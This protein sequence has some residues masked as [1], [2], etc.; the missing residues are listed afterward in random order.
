MGM[1]ALE[2]R[3]ELTLGSAGS[4]RRQASSGRRGTGGGGRVLGDGES[5]KGGESDS[6]VELHLDEWIEE[7]TDV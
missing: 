1:T 2:R 4:L 5:Q 6:A 3:K 7:T